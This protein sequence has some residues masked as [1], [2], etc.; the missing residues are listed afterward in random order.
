VSYKTIDRHVQNIYGKIGV[1]TR[2]G[3]ILWAMEHGMV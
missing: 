2:A 1:T 3:A